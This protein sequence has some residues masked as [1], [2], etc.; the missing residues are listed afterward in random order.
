[1]KK[2]IS[3]LTLF[4]FIVTAVNCEK[5]DLSVPDELRINDFV[6]KG[7]NLYYLWQADVPNLADDFVG[8]GRGQR[9]QPRG[10]RQPKQHQF[11]PARQ[12]LL[13]SA[14][15]PTAEYVSHD[16]LDRR[17]IELEHQ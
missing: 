1:M 7:M 3:L 14:G 15:R 16:P 9:F 11:R 2:L 8:M 17:G 4:L 13:R 10:G 5:D 6:W 12:R